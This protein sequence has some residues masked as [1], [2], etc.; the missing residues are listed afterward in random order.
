MGNMIYDNDFVDYVKEVTGQQI[1]DFSDDKI[2]ELQDEFEVGRL[3]EELCGKVGKEYDEFIEDM[4]RH[5]SDYLIEAAYEI[6][7]KDCINQ[8]VENEPPYLSKKEYVAL[9]SSKN[10]L[11][12]LYEGWLSNGELHTYDDIGVLLETVAGDILLSMEND[13]K[14]QASVSES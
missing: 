10:T 2:N 9:L 12:E 6:V 7:W 4:K 13:I 8:F 11:D 5:N 1:S 14:P 3:A